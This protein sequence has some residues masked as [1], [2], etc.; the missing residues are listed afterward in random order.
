MLCRGSLSGTPQLLHF[1]LSITLV[2]LPR[3]SVPGAL[4]KDLPGPFFLLVPSLP[5]DLL[6]VPLSPGWGFTTLS[7]QCA[8]CHLGHTGTGKEQPQ[9]PEQG[10]FILWQSPQG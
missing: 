8:L 4:Q 7:S 1:C 5:A 6:P 9:A 3:T 2:S 10:W